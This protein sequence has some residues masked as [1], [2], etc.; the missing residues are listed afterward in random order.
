VPGRLRRA[1][2]A[3][4]LAAA[5]AAAAA[6]AA[7]APG[8]NA[9]AGDG[10]SASAGAALYAAHCQLCHAD[11]ETRAPPLTALRALPA[12]SVR[13]SLTDGVMSTQ[14]AALDAA[15]L[16]RIVE[17]VAGTAAGNAAASAAPEAARCADRLPSLDPVYVAG[18]GFGEGQSRALGAGATAID[19]GSAGRLRLRW[20]FGL[21]GT[22]SARQQPVVAGNTVFAAS[23]GGELF[24]LDRGTGC[25]RWQQRTLA[26]LR[27]SLALGR[28]GDAPALFVTDTARHVLAV[29]A[30]D[31][32]LLWRIDI[33]LFDATL[34]TGAPVPHGDRV[35]VPLSGMETNLSRDPAYPC[36]KAH[37]AVRMLD[38]RT[39]AI[40]WTTHMTPGAK[41]V[42]VSSIGTQLWGPSGAP[43][44]GTPTV[45]AR[46]GVV[47][48]T[49]GENYQDPETDTSDAVLALDLA[50]GHVVWKFKALSGDTWN[51]NCG[52]PGTTPGPNCPLQ[53][54][55]DFDFGSGV[56]LLRDAAGRERILAGQKSGDAWALDPDVAGA[57]LWRTKVGAGSTFGG[58]HW[59]IAAADGL[60]FMPAGDIQRTPPGPGPGAGIAALD[61]TDGRIVWARTHAEETARA[62]CPFDA[63]RCRFYFRVSAAPTALP[64][65]V[66]APGLDGIVRLFAAADGR[67]L[68]QFDTVRDFPTVNGV[69]ARGGS[70]DAGG[71]AVAAG[72]WLYVQSGYSAFGQLPGNVLLAFELE[73]P[74]PH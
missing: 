70:I 60:L 28:V 48:V 51:Q 22:Q 36:C 37:G 17:F 12:A 10:G 71:G 69:P 38:A 57:V 64:G 43:V 1:A 67:L 52:P 16:D 2:A 9:P 27:S 20:A 68:W 25:I 21:P 45:D 39:G 35:V 58:V 6:A 46:R 11:P 32:A 19:A 33:G 23:T 66:V 54:G 42:R 30:R 56:I 13:M 18:W 72:D 24:A 73:P 29:D 49:T 3:A 40:L 47:Y 59:G 74:A 7:A 44:W 26:G 4:L 62:P 65:L 5:C 31:G 50:D 15:D 63:Q 61:V 34:L 41:P 55:P 14:G 8:G 53:R